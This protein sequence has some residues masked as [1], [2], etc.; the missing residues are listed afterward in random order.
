MF[1]ATTS[2]Q[3][4]MVQ[5]AYG[6]SDTGSAGQILGSCCQ[7]AMGADF[8]ASCLDNLCSTLPDQMRPH[9]IASSDG[10]RMCG[11]LLRDIVGHSN[12]HYTRVPLALDYLDM[13]LPCLHRTIGDIRKYYD[14]SSLSKDI[15]WRTMYHKMTDEAGGIP[16]PQRFALFNQYLV[17][18]DQMLIRYVHFELLCEKRRI[19]TGAVLI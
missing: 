4:A 3:I 5:G 15:R 10:L 18:L 9:I 17:L 11:R 14:D 6:M 2:N 7:E 13:L 19:L 12:I 16:L 8:V 1:L